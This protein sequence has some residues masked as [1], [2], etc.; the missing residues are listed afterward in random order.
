LHSI[1][2]CASSLVNYD[3]VISLVLL[4]T[5]KLNMK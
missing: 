1:M 5:P 3:H 2:P 4:L